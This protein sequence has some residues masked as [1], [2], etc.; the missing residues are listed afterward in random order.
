VSEALRPIRVAVWGLGRHACRNILPALSVCPDTT[1]VGVTTRNHAVARRE[2]EL[3]GC[4]FWASPELMLSDERVD[5]VYV[6]TP[7]GLHHPHG[8]E[9]LKAGKHLWSEKA[10]A[11]TFPRV[12]EL[13][14]E[15]YERDL[16]LCEGLMYL[17]HPQFSFIEDTVAQPSFG[18]VL[19]VKSQFG[20]PPLEQPG[21]RFS[22]ELGG[23]ALLDVASYPV[24]AARR[25]LGAHLDL[26]KSHVFQPSG[27]EVDTHGFA[28]MSSPSGAYSFLEWG[29]NRAYKNEISV[30]GENASLH[31]GFIF[32][33][34]SSYEA[35]V[36]VRDQHGKV[37][38]KDIEPTDSF[39]SMFSSFA[40]AVYDRESR[41]QLRQEAELQAS[42][43][44]SLQ[45]ES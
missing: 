16:A 41:D 38:H 21:F 7:T 28:L 13:V 33:K 6:A 9:V 12:Q 32:S 14:R 31:S 40:R 18:R 34:P 19:S 44:E 36:S 22:S 10:L 5:A 42:C 43:L 39:A 20:L 30:W 15:S 1:L 23:G 8:M 11:D 4:L 45:R 2:I 35:R 26:V 17:H 25:L 3:Y 24:S 29:Y 27:F 37:M